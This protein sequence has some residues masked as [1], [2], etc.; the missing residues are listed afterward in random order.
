MMSM[1]QISFVVYFVA[2]SLA[3]VAPLFGAIDTVV[4]DNIN[5]DALIVF[6]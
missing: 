3:V 5:L 4:G 2:I 6:I 1:F